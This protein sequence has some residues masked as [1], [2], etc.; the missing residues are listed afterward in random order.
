LNG[1]NET[2]NITAKIIFNFVSLMMPIALTW[3]VNCFQ[4]FFVF[5]Y[6]VILSVYF[7]KIS[8]EKIY[9]KHLIQKISAIM[10]MF[11][12]SMILNLYH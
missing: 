2:I 12:G 5:I 6:G 4:P 3:V 8:Q 9:G 7:P 10:I 11:V 1:V